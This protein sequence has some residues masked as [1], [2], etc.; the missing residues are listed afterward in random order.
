MKHF[1]L[2]AALCLAFIPAVVHAQDDPY[3][4]KIN[5]FTQ[6]FRDTYEHVRNWQALTD[7]EHEAANR[8]VMNAFASVPDPVGDLHPENIR[9]CADETSAHMQRVCDFYENETRQT[10]HRKATDPEYVRGQIAMLRM[11]DNCQAP[12]I[13][14]N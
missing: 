8:G 2:A 1:T 14:C 12:G 9:P 7:I 6:G 5:S 10:A 11:I 3:A 13:R 4:G